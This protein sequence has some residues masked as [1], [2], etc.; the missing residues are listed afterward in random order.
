MQVETQ[1]ALVLLG[2]CL[3]CSVV[4]VSMGPIPQDDAYHNF[5]DKIEWYGI[6]NGLNVLS[7]LAFL[8]SAVLGCWTLLYRD[9]VFRKPGEC[10]SRAVRG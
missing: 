4:I 8:A 2:V 7:N 1:K 10:A 5:A 3:V 9:S 6:P